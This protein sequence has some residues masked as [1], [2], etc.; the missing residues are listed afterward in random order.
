MGCPHLVVLGAGS[1]KQGAKA[2]P[3]FYW[4]LGILCIFLFIIFPTAHAHMCQ[5]LISFCIL[6]L[7]ET[8][9]QVQALQQ[10][11][12]GPNLSPLLSP[13]SKASPL[14]LPLCPFQMCMNLLQLRSVFLKGHENHSY[15]L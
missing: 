3:F 11:V 13:Y 7:Q 9:V 5:S 15:R 8:F 1:M 14:N 12:P 4:S 6:L 10:T 2:D